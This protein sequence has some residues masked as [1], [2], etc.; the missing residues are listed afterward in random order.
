MVLI[1]GHFFLD[2]AASETNISA[3]PGAEMVS[4]YEFELSTRARDVSIP[5]K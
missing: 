2:Q 1:P 4:I 5:S 3:Y